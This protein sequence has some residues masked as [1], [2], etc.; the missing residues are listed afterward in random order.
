MITNTAFSKILPTLQFAFDSTSLTALKECPRK[1]EYSIVRGY[2][3]K[4]RSYH[5]TFGILYHEALETYDHE[6]S[7]G[8]EHDRATRAAVLSTLTKTWDSKSQRPWN[9]GDQYKNRFTLVRTIVWYLDHFADDPI[10]TIQLANGRPAV[11]LSFRYEFP[12]VFGTGD[13]AIACG[14]LDRLGEIGGGVWVVDRKTTKHEL[15]ERYFQQY[16]PDNQMSWYTLAGKIIGSTPVQGVILDAAQVLVNS[17]RFQRQPISRT[18]S[19]L[20]EFIKD[21]QHYLGLAE[22]YAD[23]NY[24]PQNVTA[25]FNYGGCKFRSICSRSPE[26]RD[27]FL[28][29]ETQFTKRIWDPLIARGDI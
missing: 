11:E 7:K 8:L 13:T 5:L 21:I 27:Q 15:N 17:S 16:S 3:P 24:W 1:Y 14:H 23:D 29:D 28:N 22:Q 6:R 2:E 9:S 26:V 20:D 25:C 4:Q 12:F 10:R 19:Q 18:Q